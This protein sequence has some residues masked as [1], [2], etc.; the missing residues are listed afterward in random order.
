[1]PRRERLRDAADVAPATR[2]VGVEAI[3]RRVVGEG[4][5]G[6]PAPRR[7][8]LAAAVE[9]GEEARVFVGRRHA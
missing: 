5:L 2:R 8:F 4:P 1:M 9:P 7:A 6:A 3:R